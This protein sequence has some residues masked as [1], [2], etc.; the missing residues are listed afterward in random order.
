MTR[1]LDV[2]LE[3]ALVGLDDADDDRLSV[4][5][6]DHEMAERTKL[7]HEFSPM[8]RKAGDTKN[9]CRVLPKLYS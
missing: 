1:A 3:T 2:I 8:V 4:E 7:S 6:R 9:T 5:G